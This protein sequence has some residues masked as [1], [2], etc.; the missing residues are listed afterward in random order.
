M[1][2]PWIRIAALSAGL[3]LVLAG[4]ARGAAGE[5]GISW[6]K[7]QAL[8]HFAKPLH[9]DVADVSDL[10]ADRVLALTTLQGVVNRKIPRIYLLPG[11]GENREGKRTWLETLGIPSSTVADPM[12]L[13]AKYRDA[14]K[15]VVIYDPAVPATIN[16]A[17]TLAGLDG[18][19]VASPELAA[20]L[21]LP[22]DEDLRG[23]FR[24]DLAANT[25]AVDNLWP[26]TTHR[27]LV[28]MDP[29]FAGSVRDYAVANRALTLFL[30]VGIPEEA[31]L[32]DRVLRTMPPNSPYV[33]WFPH[34]KGSNEPAGIRF[35]SERSVY[36]VAAQ[37][38]NN[39]TV[40]SG[41]TASYAHSQRAPSIPLENKIYVTVTVS[42]GDNIAYVQ[43]LRRVLWDDPARG[44]VAIN[45]T[46][47][48]LLAD[49]APAILSYFQRTTSS[50]DYL[51]AGSSGAGY[52]YPLKWPDATLPLF[53]AQV[54]HYM[55]ETG[56]RVLKINNF[57]RT[58]SLSQEAQF[59]SAVMPLGIVNKEHEDQGSV[60]IGSRQTP[61]SDEAPIKSA[62]DGRAVLATA[63]QGWDGR[64]PRFVS[65]AAGAW[66]ITP[67][68]IAKIASS[69]DPRTYRFVRADQFFALFREANH[70]P[71]T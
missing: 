47:N 4:A 58:L 43:H 22:T 8:P 46:M 64:S 71:P 23:R 55:S 11:K 26:R 17:T 69:V 32:L 63:A 53:T 31:A 21:R 25:W 51:V 38:F 52:M 70:L 13:I 3:A 44:H 20:T 40:F 60:R 10:A 50:E 41:A 59:A 29:R 34:E 54:A 48:S 67:T 33:G 66:E 12:S 62:E 45:W 39:L 7:G 14:I 24:D 36:N 56:M 1:I 37:H 28:A 30:H 16:V 68:D 19:I 5:G 2:A 9:L 15:G 57:G 6:P 27:L 18:A 42:D 61:I 49:A 35:L 65:I